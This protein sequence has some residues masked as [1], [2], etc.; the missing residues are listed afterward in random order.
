MQIKGLS[1]KEWLC[2]PKSFFINWKL[3]G[4]KEALV[5][6]ILFLGSVKC[7][8]IHKGK[9]IIN[10]NSKYRAMIHFGFG[11]SFGICANRQEYL[12]IGKQGKIVFN[13]PAAFAPGF[14]IRV[15]EGVLVFGAYFSCNKNCFFSC[16]SG[17]S[18]GNEVLVGWN[19]NF[20]DSDGHIMTH[21]SIEK[22]FL[23]PV[24]I[25]N[26]VWIASE[27]DILKGVEIPDECV[28]GYRSCVTKKFDEPNCLIGGYPAGV[29]QKGITWKS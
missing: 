25:G 22:P 8:G 14:S 12:N 21:N 29:I 17:M 24:R 1:M 5:C 23:K 27:V 15:D 11:G 3:F 26:H 6:P 7:H 13:G 4:I 18:F 2:F 19:S 9:I 16:T 28:V 10:S 20:R